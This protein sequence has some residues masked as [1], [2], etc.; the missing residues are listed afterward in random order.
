MTEASSNSNSVDPEICIF[1]FIHLGS[2]DIESTKILSYL[3]NNNLRG[4]TP[5][6]FVEVV[7]KRLLN[8]DEG[9]TVKEV[10]CFIIKEGN[11]TPEIYPISRMDDVISK[12]KIFLGANN[13]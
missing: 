1:I 7:K 8:N 5:I 6:P 2:K 11:K 10:P 3:K 9:I 12:Y 13:V 4:I